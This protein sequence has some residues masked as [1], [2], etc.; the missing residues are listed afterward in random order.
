MS[1]FIESTKPVSNKSISGSFTAFPTSTTTITKSGT[2]LISAT[3]NTF[4]IIKESGAIG[5]VDG[6]TGMGLAFGAPFYIELK[7]GNTIKFS[8]AT[9][10][11]VLLE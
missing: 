5:T 3:D 8:A 1:Y 2:Y 11:Y 9:G 4:F 6:T 10:Q 7:A